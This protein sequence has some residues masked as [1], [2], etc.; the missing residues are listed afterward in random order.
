MGGLVD[1]DK[2]GGEGVKRSN[3]GDDIKPVVTQD[4]DQPPAGTRTSDAPANPNPNAN[5]NE[6]HELT[7]SLVLEMHD[8]KTNDG[9]M[10]VEIISSESKGLGMKKHTEYLIKG[11]DSLGEINCYRRYSEFLIFREYLYSRYPG[12]FI[13]PVPTK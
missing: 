12:L 2:Q 10:K 1:A 11:N 13:P 4:I 7:K 6:G 5:A 8:I 9:L 3:S